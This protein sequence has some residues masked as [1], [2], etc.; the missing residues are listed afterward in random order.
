[1]SF[2]E[3]LK[4]STSNFIGSF[5]NLGLFDIFVFLNLFDA[6]LK[7]WLFL[8]SSEFLILTFKLIDDFLEFICGVP[9]NFYLFVY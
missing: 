2:Y 8:G 3:F 9:N 4:D 1:M 6:K 5:P 7:Y